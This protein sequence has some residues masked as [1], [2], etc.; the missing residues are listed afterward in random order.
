MRK[1]AI[2]ATVAGLVAVVTVGATGTAHAQGLNQGEILSM[3]NQYRSE[4]D[5]PQ[6]QWSGSLAASAQAYANQ[7]LATHNTAIPHSGTTNGENIGFKSNSNAAALNSA[8]VIA[9]WYA[10]KAYMGGHYTQMVSKRVQSI[11]CGQA[12]G[13]N[14]N[15]TQT[16]MYVVCQYNPQGND[17]KPPFGPGA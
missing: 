16:E 5:N 15:N 7:L 3:H 17:G 2:F 10:E 9:G 14:S 13:P 8:D 11:G 6:V 4:V 12:V 1:I